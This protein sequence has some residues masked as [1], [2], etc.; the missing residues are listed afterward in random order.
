MDYILPVVSVRY[1]LHDDLL[2]SK[3]QIGDEVEF[4]FA[5]K[6]VG[7]LHTKFSNPDF[8]VPG[9]CLVCNI[10]VDEKTFVGN[11]EDVVYVPWVNCEWEQPCP[12]HCVFFFRRPLCDRPCRKAQSYEQYGYNKELSNF[13]HIVILSDEDG[14]NPRFDDAEIV[15]RFFCS[16]AVS[17]YE[18]EKDNLID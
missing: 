12:I 11:P 18:V 13:G 3:P 17:Q 8:G 4:D 7:K 5:V 1:I 10:K 14:R 9:E 6:M 2:L 15:Y 16:I